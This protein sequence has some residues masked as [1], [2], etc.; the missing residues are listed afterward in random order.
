M[1]A[2]KI[3]RAAALLLTIAGGSAAAHY[4]EFGGLEI[5]HPWARATVPSARNGVVYVTIA[6]TGDAADRLIGAESAAAERVELHRH[7]VED[8]VARMRAIEAIG[9]APGETTRLAP[10]GHH[11][12]LFGLT[13]PLVEWSTFPLTLIFEQAG[14]IEVE[15]MIESAVASAPAEDHGEHNAE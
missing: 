11:I 6:N 8:G 3:L 7:V 5:I 10:G 15:V 9:I 2:M 14:A 1:I 4:Y 12:M 13:G